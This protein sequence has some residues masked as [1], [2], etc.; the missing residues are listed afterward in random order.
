M[1][2]GSTCELRLSNIR[3]L[4]SLGPLCHFKLDLIALYEGLEPISLNGREMNE[5]IFAIL[6][7]DKTK[8]LG[9]V[10][11]LDCTACHLKLLEFG[12]NHNPACSCLASAWRLR[13]VI[14]TLSPVLRLCL[15][16]KDRQRF[17]WQKCKF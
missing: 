1:W 13:R 6:L 4:Q 12:V 11:P 16:N 10:K 14:V 15:A 8:A 9:F 7:G 5:Y 17:L 2:R 3:G